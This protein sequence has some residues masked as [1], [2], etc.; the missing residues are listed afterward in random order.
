MASIS[1]NDPITEQDSE[2]EFDWEEVEVP[3]HQQ[4]EEHL[5][6]TI[7]ASGP[8]LKKDAAASKFKGISHAERLKRIDCHKVHTVVLLGNAW[9]RNKWLNDELLH[10][11]LLSVTPLSLQNAFAVIHKTRIPDQHQRGRT[12]EAAM[13][14]LAEWWSSTYFE[15][16][17]NG[18]IRN[19][20]Y[21]DVQARLAKLGPPSTDPE[22]VLD[23][24]DIE[25]L[26]D[27][28]PELIRSPKSLMKHVLMQNGSRDTSAQL[29]TALCRGLGI[30]ARLVVSIQSVP[31]QTN[32][33]KPKPT[34][35]RKPKGVKGKEKAKEPETGAG[36][37]REQV[38]E[39]VSNIASA[40]QSGSEAPGKG[41][42]KEDIFTGEGQRLDGAPV[43]KSEKA[44][45]KEKAK[46]IIK[47]RKTKS[48]GNVLGSTRGPSRASSSR[49]AS[50]DPTTTPPVFWTEVFS[51]PDARW[52]PVDPIRS[53]VN[54]RKVFDPT[55]STSAPS[56]GP[57]SPL[58]PQAYAAALNRRTGGGGV[59]ARFTRQENRMLYVLA[60]EEDG[61]ARDV[62][63]RYAKEFGAKIA[64][65]Q[66][67]SSTI[68]GGGK[69]RHAWWQRVVGGVHRPYRLHR[70]DIEDEELEA[71]QMME[72]MPSTISGFK[73]HSIYV[74]QRHLKQNQVIHPPPP[75]TPELGKFRGEPV[76]PRS[77]VVTLKTAENWMRSE[78]RV[79]K[80]GCQALKMV[81]IR[82]GTINRMREL[83]VLKDELREAGDAGTSVGETMQGL[84]ARNQTEPYMPDPVVNGKV[85]KNNFGNIDL[86]VP[87]MLPRGAVHV[88]FKGVAKIA[89]KLG[90]D[91]AEAVTGFEFKKRRAF[92]V[93]EGVVVAQENEAALLE[94]Y[95]EAEQ[96]AEKKARA[97]REERV[98]KQWTRLVQGLR[99]RQRLQ[100]Q[101]AMK[102]DREQRS[103]DN[104][105]ALS[106][107][108]DGQPGTSKEIVVTMSHPGVGAGGGF[109]V[110]ADDVVEP[111]HLPKFKYQPSAELSLAPAG[112]SIPQEADMRS[113]QEPGPSPTLENNGVTYDLETMD[114]DSDEDLE[115]VDITLP[116]STDQ[117]TPTAAPKTM[118]ELAEDAARRQRCRDEGAGNGSDDVEVIDTDMYRP[119]PGPTSD[120]EADDSD[121]PKIKIAPHP[122]R[123]NLKL[124]G[125]TATLAHQEGG[126]PTTSSAPT[127]KRQ[128]GK[129][130]ARVS[131]RRASKKRARNDDTNDQTSADEDHPA[132][133]KRATSSTKASPAAAPAP[134][135]RTL[136][137]RAAKTPAQV[138]EAQEQEKAYRRAIGR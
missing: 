78:G 40:S 32:V 105:A 131:G 34:Y 23:I 103:Q 38:S 82:A 116:R 118:R 107:T 57:N 12:F 92:P 132:P 37:A 109:L 20:T 1:E 129:G 124:S 56:P 102:P 47:L 119:S 45:G 17:R 48:K 88:P 39:D 22:A 121:V 126:T 68:G 50:P 14:N 99:I 61:F 104:H 75:D 83:E 69:A 85:P 24:E 122:L 5:E 16:N 58:F 36:D 9:V 133:K 73:D 106:D 70:D 81:K 76:Y 72:G 41:N 59:N 111:F 134:P 25:D 49:Q 94:A 95:W 108:E 89:K 4:Q 18:H 96:D 137:P 101:Y 120:R 112:A 87:S 114:V 19:R 51:R 65:V 86:Y 60:F 127:T 21:E 123:V 77:A 136:R 135:T 52:I 62:T 27:E 11:R 28:D 42:G 15:V 31:W 125:N 7:S 71:A 79:V 128:K 33:G 115:E 138:R 13:A 113:Q 80:E 84:Y 93:N 3:E 6:I 2:D 29:F 53:I 97:K 30:P 91:F 67:G 55:P 74:L 100:A 63:R 54:K 64:K 35:A 44:K 117:G 130:R 10:A 98:I 43:P 110:G 46:P 66:G 8:R 90:F 26:L